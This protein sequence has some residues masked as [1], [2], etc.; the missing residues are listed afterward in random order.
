[1]LFTNIY[2]VICLTNNLNYL[3][4]TINI[5]EFKIKEIYSNLHI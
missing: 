3:L 4:S 5:T 2:N 1:M